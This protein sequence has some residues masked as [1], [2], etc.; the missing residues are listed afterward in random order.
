MKST[1]QYLKIKQDACLAFF[2]AL[3][4][5]HIPFEAIKQGNWWIDVGLKFK[6]NEGK[7]L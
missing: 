5:A 1:T 4:M 6:S 7:F 3:E 2:N